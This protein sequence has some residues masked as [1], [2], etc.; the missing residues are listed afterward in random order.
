MLEVL[1]KFVVN[2]GWKPNGGQDYIAFVRM[3]MKELSSSF[4]WK[5]MEFYNERHTKSFSKSVERL[6]QNGYTTNNLL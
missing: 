3:Q 4:T 6:R 2:A 1:K 5:E